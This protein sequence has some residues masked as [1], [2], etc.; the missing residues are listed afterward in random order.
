MHEQ[1]ANHF[2]KKQGQMLCNVTHCMQRI[3]ANT[4]PHQLQWGDWEM[5]TA[6]LCTECSWVAGLI[7]KGR[8]KLLEGTVI[9]LKEWQEIKSG[10]HQIRF[11]KLLGT[12]FLLL[13]LGT[14]VK[15]IERLY[16]YN[17]GGHST[18]PPLLCWR[19]T[20]H[21]QHVY[22]VPCTSVYFIN[23]TV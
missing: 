10:L 6:I 13:V 11:A 4:R 19:I 18:T 8:Q 20:T 15:C 9:I 14:L 23:C 2:P 17:G 21:A 16:F 1:S 22:I 5:G 12:Q 7:P 3:L